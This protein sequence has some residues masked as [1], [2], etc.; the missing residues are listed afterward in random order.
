M[1]ADIHIYAE[2]RL[3][4][5]TWATCKTYQAESATAFEDPERGASAY[6]MMFYRVGGRDYNFFAALA[7]VRGEGPI[8]KGMPDDAAPL[9]ME[10]WHSWYSDAHSHSWYSAREFVPIFMAHW[11]R[12]EERAQLVADSLAGHPISLTTKVLTHYL[13]IDVPYVND[14]P[15]VDAIRFVFWFDN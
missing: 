14:Q 8:A 3:K 12:E 9:T 2:R 13:G 4:D 10:H 5:G 1:G 7:G 6:P 11:L 15:D